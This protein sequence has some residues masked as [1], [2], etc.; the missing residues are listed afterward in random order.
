M[1]F[2][3]EKLE[4]LIKNSNI[5][6]V[7]KPFLCKNCIQEKIPHLDCLKFVKKYGNFRSSRAFKKIFFP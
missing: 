6:V 5:F 4:Y 1:W 7:K 3:G 2:L